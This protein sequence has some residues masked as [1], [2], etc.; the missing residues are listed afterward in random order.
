[1][2]ACCRNS[3]ALR[4]G[5]EG[6]MAE[7]QEWA[8]QT[9]RFAGIFCPECLGPLLV[10]SGGLKCLSCGRNLRVNGNILYLAGETNE[11]FEV[12]CPE[13]LKLLAQNVGKMGFEK[14]LLSVFNSIPAEQYL[15]IVRLLEPRQLGWKLLTGCYAHRKILVVETDL[16]QTVLELAKYSSR[17]YLLFFNK[18]RLE[19]VQERVRSR[20]IKNILCLF[21][22]NFKH[23]SFRD[24][25]FDSAVLPNISQNLSELSE[26]LRLK[27]SNGMLWLLKEIFR[28]LVPEGEVYVLGENRLNFKR[29]KSLLNGMSAYKNSFSIND[30]GKNLKRVGFAR[31]KT[32]ILSPNLNNVSE[33]VEYQGNWAYSSN[34]VKELLLKGEGIFRR[35]APAFLIIGSK[36]AFQPN[37]AQEIIEHWCKYALKPPQYQ[38]NNPVIKRFLIGS[39][40]VIILLVGEKK[41]K[42]SGVVF[43]IPL[44][45][46]SIRRCRANMEVLTEITQNKGVM[47]AKVPCPLWVGEFEGHVYFVESEIRG[48]IIDRPVPEIH[49]ISPKAIDV[50]IQF[51]RETVVETRINETLFNSLI[52]RPLDIMTAFV[53]REQDFLITKKL[54]I[55]LRKAFLNKVFPLVRSHGDFKIENM[56]VHPQSGDIEGII[57]WDLSQ[58][59]G[60]P[61]LDL[62]Y[63]MMFNQSLFLYRDIGTLIHEKLV[64]WQLDAS[65]KFIID[66]YLNSFHISE[67]YLFP[68]VVMYWL[69]HVSFRLDDIMRRNHLLMEHYYFRILRA[70]H[71]RVESDYGDCWGADA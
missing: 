42:E 15:R 70:V 54:Q 45:K 53:D 22:C 31:N 36:T 34:N 47:V 2:D 4:D 64:P 56:I 23:L 55:F 43:R 16:G 17:V 32:Y 18:N 25:F 41:R 28:V 51:H 69:Y 60:L 65:E 62:L 67:E 52:A 26:V 27:P 8:H 20:G 48:R 5:I 3:S 29:F 13:Y 7:L 71:E 58:R 66:R 9:D 38:Y 63:F 30:M 21:A 39:P 6:N 37:M 57:D 14:G 50:L 59:Q 1:M 40:N 35:F 11:D 61:L 33:I 24:H 12:R 46:E 44:E 10:I 49:S 68:L 19:C